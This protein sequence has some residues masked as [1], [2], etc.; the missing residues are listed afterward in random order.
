MWEDDKERTICYITENSAAGRL[1]STAEE[2]HGLSD[3]LSL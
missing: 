2:G 1:A 3:M